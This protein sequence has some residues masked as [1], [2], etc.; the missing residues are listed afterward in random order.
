VTERPVPGPVPRF[1]LAEW[2]ERY[3]IVAGITGRGPSVPPFDLG[4]AG[5]A[6][7]VGQVLQ[8]W[9]DLEAAVPGCRGLV[10]SRQV[11]GTRVAWH[12]ALRGLTILQGFD[13]HAT[14]TPGAY[15]AVS[16]AD[17]VPVYV[18]D[19]VRR[20]VALLHA[21]WR[22][23]AGKI[24]TRGL[25]E[26]TGRGSRVEDLVVHCGVGICG[27]CY[28][29]GPEVF[30]GCGV[31]AP[32]GGRGGL[33]LRELLAEEARAAG[34]ETVSTSQFCSAHD[35]GLFF[36]HRASHGADGRMVAYLGIMA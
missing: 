23:T 30:A 10:V 20:T 28:E 14:A 7:P 32:A 36:S 5:T 17:C 16:A 18:A 34:V 19:P 35:A 8:R 26:L 11:H 6:A 1:E 12:D 21:G 24:L 29:V 27:R 15:L 22:G 3:G 4:L 13:G 33:D 25:A 9:H 2:R 31:P